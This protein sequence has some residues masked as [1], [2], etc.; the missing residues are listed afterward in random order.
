[1]V[2]AA[3]SMIL[4]LV[5]SVLNLGFSLVVKS[6]GMKNCLNPALKFTTDVSIACDA[7][8]FRRGILWGLGKHWANG[9]T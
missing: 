6:V 3:K 7:G 2:P 8:L 4:S 1:M 9:N 5:T